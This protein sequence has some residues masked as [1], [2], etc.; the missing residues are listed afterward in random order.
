MAQV[1]KDFGFKIVDKSNKVCKIII[2]NTQYYNERRMFERTVE[3]YSD[4]NV[5]T[6][7]A[8]EIVVA[9]KDMN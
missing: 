2:S 6:M 5:L 4:K 7:T 8:K 3:K 9:Q 1:H